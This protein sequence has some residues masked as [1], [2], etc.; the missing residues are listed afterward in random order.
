[1]L[2][3]R[4][5]ERRFFTLHK[6]SYGGVLS[7]FTDDMMM[8]V[9]RFKG[10]FAVHINSCYVTDLEAKC[11][12]EGKREATCLRFSISTPKRKELVMYAETALEKQKWI[13]ALKFISTPPTLNK[14]DSTTSRR[15]QSASAA[16]NRSR[17]RSE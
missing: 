10:S 4:C 16:G 5:W 14:S 11:R 9:F 6:T 13:S 1:M 12:R 3:R 7:Y 15:V 8:D 17:E 2:R